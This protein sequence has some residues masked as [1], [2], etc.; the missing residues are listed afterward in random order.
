MTSAPPQILV[1][2]TNKCNLN[3]KVCSRRLQKRPLGEMEPVGFARIVEEIPALSFGLQGFGEPLMAKGL[4]EAV[5]IADKKG[6]FTNFT[7]NGTLFSKEVV[8]DLLSSRLLSSIA[9]SV[10][11]PHLEQHDVKELKESIKTLTQRLGKRSL[12]TVTITAMLTRKNLFDGLQEVLNLA[13]ECEVSNV[14]L[15]NTSIFEPGLRDY[16]TPEEKEIAELKSFV[17]EKFGDLNVDF[18]RLDL[19]LNK[20]N[21]KETSLCLAPWTGCFISWE[22]DVHPCCSHL[23]EPMGNIFK[24]SFW[25]IW[26]GKKY[27]AFRKSLLENDFDPICRACISEEW[28]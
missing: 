5:K 8:E 17:A 27:A 28:H 19:Y 2:L 16:A 21:K 14:Y 23:G 7:S 13:R 10:D 20:K 9:I 11:T 1:E 3:C 12:P 25:E 26:N 24:Q 18:S 4:G 6:R 15:H 22:G